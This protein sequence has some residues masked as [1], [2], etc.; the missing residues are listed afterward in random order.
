MVEADASFPPCVRRYGCAEPLAPR[1]LGKRR[2]DGATRA[3]VSSET[4]T[5]WQSAAQDREQ[6]HALEASFI[7]WVTRATPA[8]LEDIPRGRHMLRDAA[9]L[10]GEC[11]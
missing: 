10:E 6:W 9:G 11:A 8:H 5:L 3:T 4:D 1:L 7:A 2:R